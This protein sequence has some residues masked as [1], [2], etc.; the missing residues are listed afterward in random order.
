MQCMR[1]GHIESPV[2]IFYSMNVCNMKAGEH[3]QVLQVELEE[4]VR[5]RLRYLG[6]AAGAELVLL[7]ISLF[8]KTYF[9]QAQSAKLAIGRE[10]AE[11]ISVCKISSS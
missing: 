6:I 9:V 2:R 11:G 7:K 8:K 4:P 1:T 3:A 5:Q 10:V